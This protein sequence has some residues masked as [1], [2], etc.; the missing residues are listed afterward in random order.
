LL[1]RFRL[2]GVQRGEIKAGTLGDAQTR[3]E[4]AL[5]W[6]GTLRGVFD[7]VAPIGD[8]DVNTQKA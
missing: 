6:G 5:T 1:A 7:I 4:N 3:A 8:F 2:P